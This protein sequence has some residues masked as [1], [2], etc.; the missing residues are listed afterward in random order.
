MLDTS[1]LSSLN[2][3][4]IGQSYCLHDTLVPNVYYFCMCNLFNDVVFSNIWQ[5]NEL[6]GLYQEEA[7]T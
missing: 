3:Q 6:Y 1:T 7:L 5:D 2:K 4:I